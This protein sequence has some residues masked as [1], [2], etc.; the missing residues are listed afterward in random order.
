MMR[1]EKNID[2][3]KVLVRRL[4][5]L[6][7]ERSVYTLMPRCAY[8][9]GAYTVEKDG[10]LAVED[11]NADRGILNTLLE[12]GMIIGELPEEGTERIE[13]VGADLPA[14][15]E[16]P[17]DDSD[18]DM[19]PL[20]DGP[21]EPELPADEDDDDPEFLDISFPTDKHTGTSL[22]NL[23]YLLYSRGP[24]INK[25]VGTHFLVEKSLVDALS[26]DAC[27][28]SQEAFRRA[29]ADYE[30][31]DGNGLGM[32][33]ITITPEQVTLH[34]FPNSDADHVKACTELAAL[35]NEMAIKQKRIQAKEIT[36]ENEKY[37]FRIWLLRLGMNG[38]EYKQT[39]KLLLE[40][41]DGN[42][43]FRTEED[44]ERFKAKEKQ[45]RDA[46][47][48]AKAEAETEVPE[49]E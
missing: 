41:L 43:A 45:K 27:V 39:R 29:I 12:E 20:D 38:S 7:G 33:G 14:D 15:D 11:G 46:A 34:G 49:N 47:K 4:E 21:A 24:A 22:R 8:E 10:T 25:A 18:E 19:L 2:D 36:A 31:T 28:K 30:D 26:D 17:A 1:F 23:V 13:P 44:A 37:A 42:S 32:E 3:R 40:N 35:M 5:E 6:T 9:I 48:A 16:P